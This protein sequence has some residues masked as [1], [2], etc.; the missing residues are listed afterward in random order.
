MYKTSGRG[1]QTVVRRNQA[2]GSAAIIPPCVGPTS[3]YA[4]KMQEV[5]WIYWM[6]LNRWGWPLFSV[7]PQA[8]L[9]ATRVR[10]KHKYKFSMQLWVRVQVQRS[11]FRAMQL[12]SGAR[13]MNRLRW[14]DGVQACRKAKAVSEIKWLKLRKSNIIHCT[15]K[16]QSNCGSFLYHIVSRNQNQ[17]R[18]QCFPSF[19]VKDCL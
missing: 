12:K 3:P 1:V 2:S 17:R 6:K 18:I 8:S 7:Q 4:G 19:L 13:W 10:C 11:I 16:M 9:E 15:I 14:T 5:E